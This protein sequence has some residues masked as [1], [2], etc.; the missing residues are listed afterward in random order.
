VKVSMG[1]GPFHVAVTPGHFHVAT[2]KPEPVLDHGQ[3]GGYSP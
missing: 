3:P 2:A 1:G